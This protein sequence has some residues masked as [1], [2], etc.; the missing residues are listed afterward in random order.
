MKAVL[1]SKEFRRIEQLPRRDWSEG[2]E[3]LIDTLTESLKTPEGTMRLREVQAAALTEIGLN[4]GL[5]A[6]VGVGHGKT[7]IS[8][9][10]PLMIN[11][12]RPLLLVPAQLRAATVSKY[13]RELSK[14]WH[15]PVSF[16]DG[17]MVVSYSALSTKNG[18][19]LLDKLQPDLIIC[20][21]VHYL[22]HA[23]SARTKRFLR[24]MRANPSTRFVGMS[25]TVT[26]K[27][28]REYW[29]LVRLALPEACPL[30]TR[31]VEMN[32]WANAL[33]ENVRPEMR[34]APGALKYLCEGDET[35]REGYRRRLVQ[36]PGVLCTR[37]S[38]LGTSLVIRKD[39]PMPTTRIKRALNDLQSEWVTP[40]GEDVSDSLDFYRKARELSLGFY[41]RWVWDA[42][43]SEAA[44]ATWLNSRAQWRR[45]VREQTSRGPYDTELLVANAYASG[46]L[47]K[48]SI[49]FW[50]W[51]EV[52]A[53]TPPPETEAVWFCDSL[54]RRVTLPKEPCLIWVDNKALADRLSELLELPYYG[55]GP[56]DTRRLLSH[57]ENKDGHAILSIQAHGTGKNLQ[58]YN[59]SL[60]LTCPSSGATWEQLLGRLHRPGQEADEVVF[61]VWTHT[62]PLQDAF[63]QAIADASY[64]ETTL[65]SKQKLSY[66]SVI[67]QRQ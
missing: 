3:S 53:S 16:C 54:L 37:E 66:A 58:T 19:D 55:A 13:C 57:I 15:I 38:E 6:P 33:D 9:L 50:D 61:R 48:D 32:D 46:D 35:P 12:E 20:D 60:V 47:T 59:Q 2:A 28:I 65:G 41:Y 17:S 22:K 34:T 26:K 45:L 56:R 62:K 42:S 25:G 67:D 40:S 14:H 11:C 64:I 49:L 31:W 23:R 27:S 30:P 10:A 52:K 39:R 1:R 7:L 18:K 63:N 44:K 5:F 21:E 36:T 4:R 24:Y 8:L 43:V 29:H 51:R